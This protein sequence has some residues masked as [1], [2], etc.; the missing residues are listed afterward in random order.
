MI[1]TVQDFFDRQEKH[2]FPLPETSKPYTKRKLLYGGKIEVALKD[3]GTG[4]VVLDPSAEKPQSLI[5]LDTDWRELEREATRLRELLVNRDLTAGSGGVVEMDVMRSPEPKI[6]QIKQR[7]KKMPSNN[8]K[9]EASVNGRTKVACLSYKDFTLRAID[10]LRK[11]PAR[12]IHTVWSGFNQAAVAY[13]A[14]FGQ[15]VNPIDIV[16]GL[17]KEGSIAL[18]PTKGGVMIYAPTDAPKYASAESKGKEALAAIL[19][20]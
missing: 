18:K 5:I 3:N 7:R 11:P 13:Y 6:G 17:V 20:K 1:N 14:E 15:K 9:T 16:Q 19:G 2:K 4:K 12:G 10:R 8:K